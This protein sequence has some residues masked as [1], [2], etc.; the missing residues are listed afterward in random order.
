MRIENYPLVDSWVHLKATDR[1]KVRSQHVL[2]RVTVLGGS[3]PSL[4]IQLWTIGTTVGFQRIG[5]FGASLVGTNANG[6]PVYK[7]T[8]GTMRLEPAWQGFHLGTWCQTLA[9]TW[10]K[11]Q[12]LGVVSSIT[13]VE[14]DTIKERSDGT[15]NNEEKRERRNK[16]YLRY[17]IEFDW[18]TP[19]V[20]G[21]SKPMM[22]SQ[23]KDLPQPVG[24][25]ESELTR[26]MHDAQLEVERLTKDLENARL[27]AQSSRQELNARDYWGRWAWRFVGPS[28]I[29]V[30]LGMAIRGNIG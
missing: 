27:S 24:L 14:I 11:S 25:V 7:I 22:T 4:G 5:S 23:L 13:L 2:A 15:D 6:D 26:A 19:L 10:A 12:P 30:F 21:R 9:V 1:K 8:D 3:K 29:G 18:S 16:F 20:E 28:L 17:G